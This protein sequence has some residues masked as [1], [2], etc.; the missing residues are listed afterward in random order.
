MQRTRPAHSTPHSPHRSASSRLEEK[1]LR[2]VQVATPP[3]R[4]LRTPRPGGTEHQATQAPPYVRQSRARVRSRRPSGRVPRG[5]RTW[6]CAAAA[7]RRQ[8]RC[9]AFT[10]T[11]CSRLPWGPR[12]TPN[13]EAA[14]GPHA[15]STRAG[16]GGTVFRGRLHV[17]WRPR[18]RQT[19]RPCHPP[20]ERHTKQ[21]RLR[22]GDA[23]ASQDTT[24]NRT[25]PLRRILPRAPEKIPPGSSP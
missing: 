17:T 6:A 12:W 10:P 3:S 21:S 13:P 7:R 20:R 1:T 23:Q 9:C 22:T 4:R 15:T 8:P 18:D 14:R 19:S 5:E 11:V 2:Y 25:A 24:R 16:K